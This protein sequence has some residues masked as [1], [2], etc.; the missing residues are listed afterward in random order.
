MN[1]LELKTKNAARRAN[2]VR[3]VVK[4]VAQRPRLSVHISNLHIT[5]QVIDDSAGKTLAYASTVGKDFSGSKTERAAL[6]G[7]EIAAKAKTAKIK[8]VA[9]DRGRRKYHGRIK[10]LADAARKEGLEF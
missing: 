9:F 8:Q 6:L 1:R 2:R 3:T 7:T 4:G 5:A 10:A